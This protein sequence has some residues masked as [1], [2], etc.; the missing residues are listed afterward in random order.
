ML[1]REKE[2][3]VTEGAGIVRC[4]RE[5]EKSSRAGLF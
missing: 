5:I 3:G 2:R 1:D 4:G